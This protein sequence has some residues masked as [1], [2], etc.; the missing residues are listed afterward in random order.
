MP[1]DFIIQVIIMFSCC[2]NTIKYYKSISWCTKSSP[3]GRDFISSTSEYSMFKLFSGQIW[4]EWEL[5]FFLFFIAEKQFLQLFTFV[6]SK[7]CLVSAI[8]E[9]SAGR[10]AG[11]AAARVFPGVFMTKKRLKW[12][13]PWFLYTIAWVKLHTN[14][15]WPPT[16]ETSSFTAI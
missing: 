3:Q 11:S 15:A 12:W 10:E 6:H 8:F 1:T 14:R 4:T 16:N 13:L 5:S 7:Q 2:G 9:G